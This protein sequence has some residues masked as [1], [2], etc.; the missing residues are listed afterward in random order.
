MGQLPVQDGR[1][2]A[3]A[4]EE[5]AWSRVPLNQDDRALVVGDTALQPVQAEP[6]QRVDRAVRPGTAP[7]YRGQPFR[8]VLAGRP[9]CPEAG[10]R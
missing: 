10:N 1:D 2:P 7:P 6:Q 4:V 3:I 5:V 8:R 9:G